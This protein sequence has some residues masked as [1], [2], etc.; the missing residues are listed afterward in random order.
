MPILELSTQVFKRT[1]STVLKDVNDDIAVDRGFQ[2]DVL[3]ELPLGAGLVRPVGV[4]E[5]DVVAGCHP[6]PSAPR[7]RVGY[8]ALVGQGLARKS[9]EL[10]RIEG[11]QP[12]ASP[13]DGEN[14]RGHDRNRD[15]GDGQ[16]RRS[17]TT[18][19]RRSND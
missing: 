6:R 7:Q 3:A 4:H 16:S 13:R 19:T 2:D 5:V 11:L 10:R 17:I 12:L 15:K 1:D 8:P 14:R 18:P 9:D